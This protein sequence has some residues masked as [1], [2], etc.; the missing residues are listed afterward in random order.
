MLAITP[1]PVSA[2]RVVVWLCQQTVFFN[3]GDFNGGDL[4][5]EDMSAHIC[6]SGE[7]RLP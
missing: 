1:L 3:G 7:D 6:A 2:R 5:E 4:V